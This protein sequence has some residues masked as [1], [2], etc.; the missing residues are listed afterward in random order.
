MMA[1]RGRVQREGDVIHVVADRLI[2]LSELLRQV[3]DRDEP[4]A[5][6]AGRGDEARGGGGPDARDPALGRKARD[7]YI[8]DLR[9][10][11]DTIPV[12]ARNFR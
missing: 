3:G 5:L 8:P 10:E 9:I 7:I 6:P 12:K 1:C 11:R 4:L 2:D